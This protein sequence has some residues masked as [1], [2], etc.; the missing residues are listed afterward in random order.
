ME[1][2]PAGRS[3][4]ALSVLGLSTSTWGRETDTDDAGASLAVFRDAGGTVVDT[5]GHNA[6]GRAE[7]IVGSLLSGDRDA[8]TIV[9]RTAGTAAGTAP[10]SRA[11]L[12]SGLTD[13]LRRL[14]CD[15][16][17][18]WL[19]PPAARAVPF[20]EALGTLDSAVAA[21]KV[22]YAGACEPVAW[23]LARA[24]VWQGAWPGRTPIIA[25]QVP[26][27]LLDRGIESEVVPAALDLGV[28]LLCAA[29]LAGGL[30][31][32]RYRG[33]NSGAEP[34]AWSGDVRAAG[35]VEAVATAAN[36]LA[37]TALAVSLS[38]L[39]ER[40][41]VT[42]LIVGARNAAEVT[43]AVQSLSVSIPPTI[44]HALDEVSTPPHLPR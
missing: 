29:T 44:R 32:G 27:S 37:T 22:R 31:T 16:V 20:E 14:R 24:A 5:A 8:M 13:S 23:H 3:G 34:A 36:G 33:A 17:D 1:K 4:L 11:A 42:S 40:P 26:Y 25:N 2:R 21:G 28:G 19:L 35:I 6:G 43:A 9:S 18:L 41:G 15:H 10:S 39:R 12:L 7:S 38:W 30:L